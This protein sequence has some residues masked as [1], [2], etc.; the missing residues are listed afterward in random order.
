[1]RVSLA[2]PRT[3]LL[4]AWVFVGLYSFLAHKARAS[5]GAAAEAERPIAHPWDPSGTPVRHPC[6]IRCPLTAPA[7]PASVRSTLLPF[8]TL[9]QEVRF[10][11]PVLLLFNVGA[12]CFLS[13]AHLNR[14]KSTAWRFVFTGGLLALAACLA[15]TCVMSYAA[16][17]NYP[18]RWKNFHFFA[19][20]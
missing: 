18:V 13:K 8:E 4:A 1:M 6:R 15:A 19:G 16:Y 11:F 2:R 7:V 9:S 20:C 5:G 17:W 14:R 12:A 10:L 3:Q